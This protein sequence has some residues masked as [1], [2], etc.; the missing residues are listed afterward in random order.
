MRMAHFSVGKDARGGTPEKSES[1]SKRMEE[2]SSNK[3]RRTE[4]PAKRAEIVN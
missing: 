3:E 4:M 1:L 2:M